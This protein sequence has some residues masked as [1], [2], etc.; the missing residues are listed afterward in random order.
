VDGLEKI[1]VAERLQQISLS[2]Q[3]QGPGNE[4]ILREAREDQDFRG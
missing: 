3:L 1:F 4:L 2:A